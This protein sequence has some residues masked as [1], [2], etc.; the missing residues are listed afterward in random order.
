[1]IE[2]IRDVNGDIT[3]V[4]EWLLMNEDAKIDDNG[5][6]VYIGEIE[7]NKKHQNN[8]IIKEF[9]KR[10]S[11]KC[12]KAEKVFFVRE[13]KYPGRK[14]RIYTREQILRRA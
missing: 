14:P 2:C 10:I 7:I 3:A 11:E 6:F 5:R 9:I 12:P 4:C 8:G 13:Y 1:M